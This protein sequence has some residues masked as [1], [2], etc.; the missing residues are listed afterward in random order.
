MSESGDVFEGSFLHWKRHGWGVQR[1]A[2]G[3]VFRGVWEDD[4]QA[5]GVFTDTQGQ[6]WSVARDSQLHQNRAVSRAQ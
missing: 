1:W 5:R 6:R 2:S 3:E 4:A